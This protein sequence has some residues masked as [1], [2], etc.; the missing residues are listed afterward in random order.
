MGI[1]QNDLIGNVVSL[2]WSSSTSVRR[3][4]INYSITADTKQSVIIGIWMPCPKPTVFYK[5]TMDGLHCLLNI[6]VQSFLWNNPKNVGNNQNSLGNNAKHL[7]NNTWTIFV[8]LANIL[9][10]GLFLTLGLFINPWPIFWH[11]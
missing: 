8:H 4:I 10:P 2:Q 1:G 3:L 9:T 7:G 5:Q 11:T 6:H